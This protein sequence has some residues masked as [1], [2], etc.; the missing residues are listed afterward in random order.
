MKSIM[1]ISN[2]IDI[3]GYVDAR[4]VQFLGKA[5]H[6]SDNTYTCL[7]IVDSALCV[8]EVRIHKKIDK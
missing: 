1:P 3:D 8:V 2:D 4:G 6:V 7:A 5:R